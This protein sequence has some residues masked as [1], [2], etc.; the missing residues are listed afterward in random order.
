MWWLLPGM[1]PDYGWQS[2]KVIQST[3]NYLIRIDPNEHPAEAVTII[4]PRTCE[5]MNAKIDNMV[6]AGGKIWLL[7]STDEEGNPVPLLQS[8]D[9]ETGI[10]K[11]PF[12][13]ANCTDDYC[14]PATGMGG[15]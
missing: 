15:H 12:K 9:P 2:A 6:F 4:R 14:I 13:F 10:A 7:Y 11:T 8:I 5:T 1:G 3:K